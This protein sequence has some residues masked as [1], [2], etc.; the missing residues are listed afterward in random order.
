MSMLWVSIALITL[1]VLAFISFPLIRHRKTKAGL[2]NRFEYDV[3]LYQDQLKEVDHDLEQGLLT[4]NQ[5]DAVRTEIQRK[6][7]LSVGHEETEGSG[8]P[9]LTSSHSAIYTLAAIVL[10]ISVGAVSSYSSLGS[11]GLRNIAY[12]DRDIKQEET[13]LANWQAEQDMDALLS[14]L[15]GRLAERP[16][17]IKGW[18]MLGRSLL[19]RGRYNEAVTAY[20]HIVDLQPDNA[21]IVA[22]YAEALIFVNE[23]AVDE[24]ALEILQGVF[25]SAP[26]NPKIRYYIGLSK[27]QNDDLTGALQDWTDIAAI[28]PKDAPWMPT[29]RQQMDAAFS[30]T[31]IAPS[32]IKP[33]PEALKI[34]A[35]LDLSPTPGPTA[36]DMAA[37][38]QM[39]AEDQAEMINSMVKRL[40]GK[41]AANPNN[42]GGWARLGRSYQTLNRYEE[43]KQAYL[44][45]YKQAPE[46]LDI[47]LAYGES[48]VFLDQGYV[49]PTARAVFEQVLSTDPENIKARF[50]FGIALAETKEE[51]P[52][53]IQIWEA[54]LEDLPEGAP[55]TSSVIEQ[56][57]RAKEA[58]NKKAS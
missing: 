42:P 34:A 52:R 54:L 8:T 58:I 5:A 6:L 3:A 19:A 14:Q 36:E 30:E 39:S 22:D 57:K 27:A 51:T 25:V 17:D 53:A 7:L 23:G 46:N 28:S 11:P 18:R 29:V 31:G 26:A 20:K 32:S 21:E 10:F 44:R 43:S 48:L 15:A 24:T 33:T 45:A 40:A 47:A 38:R 56:I 16:N 55:W 4:S 12:V 37:A 1:C 49:N 2:K 13:V 50:Y 35:T 41:L 9:A